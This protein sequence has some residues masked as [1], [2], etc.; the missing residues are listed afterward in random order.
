MNGERI[1]CGGRWDQRPL[2]CLRENESCLI[3]ISL[4]EACPVLS[5]GLMLER[6]GG[7]ERAIPLCPD[8]GDGGF[9]RFSCRF[10]IPERGLYR[11][12]FSVKTA[13]DSFSLY[14]LGAK[15]AG[16]GTG[17][18]WQI[19]CLPADYSVPERFR[20]RGIYQIFPDRFAAEGCCDLSGKLTPF[21][22]RA[23]RREPPRKGPDERGVWNSDFYGGNFRGIL[24]RLDYLRGLGVGLIYLNPIFLARSNHRYDT[25][26]YRRIDPMLGSEEE[27]SL[28]CREAERRGMGVLLDGVFSHVGADSRYFDAEGRFGGGAMSDPGS[29]YRQ[30]FR[31]RRYPDDYDCWWGI[32]SLPCVE[33]MTP[34]FLEFIITGE[35]SVVAHWMRLGACGFRLDVADELPDGFIALLRKR[36]RELNPDGLVIGEVWEDASDHCAYGERRRYFSDGELDGVTNYPFRALILG[37]LLRELPPQGFAEGIMRL[38]ERYPAEALDCCMTILSTHDT[39][40]VRSVLE[41]ALSV[42]EAERAHR[43]AATLQYFLPGMPCLYYGDETGM[44]GGSDPDNRGWFREEEPQLIDYY[45]WLGRLRNGSEALR[46]GSTEVTAGTDRVTVRRSLG[47]EEVSLTVWISG[48]KRFTV[49]V[50]GLREDILH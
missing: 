25:A 16:I 12:Y 34:S 29:P 2:G 30:W 32:K 9:R 50:D 49:C 43:A 27:F 6:D 44:R 42:Q 45:R 48:E 10:S 38:C 3:T 24:A 5:M 47:R 14:R 4:P 41:G 23:D 20:G 40:R 35:D 19:T 13:Q 26:D 28:L 36:V 15:E 18:K 46:R 33:E 1:R 39:P 11:Y 22:L 31:F 37:L 17:E 8:G 7:G 21:T